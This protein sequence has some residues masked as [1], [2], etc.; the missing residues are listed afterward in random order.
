M[1]VKTITITE[2]AYR[3]LKAMKGQKESFSG[4]IL[5]ITKKKSL[6]EFFGILT[7]KEGRALEKT[8]ME[9][10]KISQKLFK[11]KMTRI[12]KEL[13]SPP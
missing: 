9:Q 10:R 4:T 13:R 7:E 11:K 12:E 5:R 8:I 1:A 3:S 2:E 6:D